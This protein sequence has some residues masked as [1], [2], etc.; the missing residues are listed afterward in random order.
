ML[1]QFSFKAAR[2]SDSVV[3]LSGGPS[4]TSNSKAIQ[5]YIKENNSLVYAVNYRHPDIKADYTYLG[6]GD[7][8]VGRINTMDSPVL[9]VNPWTEKQIRNALKQLTKSWKSKFNKMWAA[10]QKKHKMFRMG[11][12]D[13]KKNGVLKKWRGREDGTFNFFP[14]PGG[15]AVLVL[16]TVS[17]PKSVLI[18]GLD[19]PKNPRPGK[20][21]F[22]HNHDG[23]VSGYRSYESFKYKQR[24]LKRLAIPYLKRRGIKMI[25]F[26]D[27]DFWGLDPK[28]Y[29]VEMI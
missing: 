8:F 29:G 27:S 15:F 21:F 11:R 28:K 26:K 3:V 9:I 25:S 1:E 18:A 5:E 14:S 23:S 12:G 24:I 4:A 16:S 17:Q 7:R 2:Q 22:K 13:A 20:K 10:A 6:N 19:G